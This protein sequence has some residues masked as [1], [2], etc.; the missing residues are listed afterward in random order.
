MNQTTIKISTLTILIIILSVSSVAQNK[1]GDTSFVDKNHLIGE[2]TIRSTKQTKELKKAI[3]EHKQ[4]AGGTNIAVL[5]PQSQRLE[6]LKDALKLEPG[7][8]IQEFFGANDQPR[9]N[10]RGSGIQSNPQRRGVFLMQDGIPVNFADGSY[11]IGVVNPTTAQFV[12]VF[13]GA[14]AMQYGTATLG[15]VLDFISRRGTERG[16]LFVK[17]QAGSFDYRSAA[18]MGGKKWNK[19]DIYASISGSKQKGFRQHNTNENISI[20]LNIGYQINKSIQ[21]TFYSNYSY[22]NFDVPGPLTY[23]MI[24][25]DPTQIT[26]GVR[27]P[28]YMAANIERDKPK[29]EVEMLRIADKIGIILNENTN[30]NISAYYQYAN[31]RFVF[32]IVL[33]TQHSFY[34][35][36]GLSAKF[37][38][39]NSNFN[40]SAGAISSMGFIERNGHINKDGLDSYLFSKDNLLAYNFTLFAELKYNIKERLMLVGG[41]QGAFNKRNSKDVFPEPELRPWY[42][43]SSHKY[44]YFYSENI[45]KNQDYKAINPRLGAIFNTGAKK[46]FQFFANTTCSYEPPTFDELVGTQVINNTNTSPKKLFAVE[47]KKQQAITVELGTRY[48]G[49]RYAWNIATYRS[50]LKDEILEVKDFVLGIKTTKNYPNTIHNGVEV[51]IML[52]PLQRLLS[53]RNIDKI[54]IQAVYNYSDFQFS[55]GK[56][57]G[58][59][60]AGIPKH[61]LAGAL[62]YIY[63]K[64]FTAEINVELQPEET[65]VDHE[66][67]LTQ[68]SFCLWGFKLAYEGLKHFS[69]F[70]E[71]KNIK[72]KR[73]ASS[74]II[75]DQIHS[76][77]IPFPK[78]TSKN[79]AFFVPGA[80]RAFYFGVSYEL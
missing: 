40:L 70:V 9:L 67:T 23:K 33:S 78:F 72:D 30:L 53:K 66:N 45:S 65:P 6:T 73:Y 2:I 69:F 4:I 16:N 61:Y 36:F 76:P 41:I 20:G 13:K 14:N 47:L 29:R 34:H 11:V 62:R 75:N 26:K 27:L 12:E 52:V 55:S 51:G 74:Y 24:E 80:P 46:D 54:Q 49:T 7:V 17:A 56:Y 77:P 10:I 22:I 19:T 39:K 59:Q 79:M 48:A 37:N 50:W 25:N 42:S 63:P 21:N 44:R 57:K 64:Q 43:H 28:M 1:V 68:P 8:M 58:K 32:P 5:T 31:D 35:D 15:G 71:G 18:I 38:Y 3:L 60:L